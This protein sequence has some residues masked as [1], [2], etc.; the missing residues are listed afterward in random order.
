MNPIQ[1]G[2]LTKKIRKEKKMSQTEFG[3]YLGIHQTAV[4]RVEAGI[5]QLSATEFL[6]VLKL[7]KIELEL[8]KG[9]GE[10]Q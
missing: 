8:E 9:K 3:D 4:H 5:Q 6:M 10:G 2:K 1:I 7:G